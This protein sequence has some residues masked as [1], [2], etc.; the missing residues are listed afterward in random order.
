[1]SATSKHI[2][3]IDGKSTEYETGKCPFC[4]PNQ[5]QAPPKAYPTCYRKGMT[6]VTQPSKGV[7]STTT[8]WEKEKVILHSVKAMQMDASGKAVLDNNKKP[9]WN[10]QTMRLNIETTRQFT[11]ELSKLIADIEKKSD[12][13]VRA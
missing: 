7:M 3:V 12:V 9:L 4:N 13:P 6:V 8:Y 2:H 1:M 5:P 10:Q 11:M